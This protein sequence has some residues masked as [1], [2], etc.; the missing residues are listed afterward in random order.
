MANADSTSNEQDKENKAIHKGQNLST[1]H[2]V[3]SNA[4]LLHQTGY[5][6]KK[7]TATYVGS[8]EQLSYM[9][10]AADA[11]ITTI[12][13]G[14]S[15]IGKLLVRQDNVMNCFGDEELSAIGWLLNDLGASI[16]ALQNIQVAAGDAV[17]AAQEYDRV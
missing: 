13:L 14:I 10:N 8:T 5:D 6:N 1:L 16:V 9:E 4:H 12:G 2:C 3:I 7:H 15:A 11:S 17:I